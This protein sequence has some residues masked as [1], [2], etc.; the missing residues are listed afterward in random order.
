MRLEIRKFLHD[1][2]AELLGLELNKVVWAN[3]DGVKQKNPLVTLM[4][5]SYQGEAMEDK[6][7]TDVAGNMEIKTPTAFVLEIRYFG[8]KNSAPT[9]E[10]ERLVRQLERPTIVDKFFANGVA[11]LYAAPVQDIT[12]LLENSQQF[13]PRAA[14]DLHCR[15]T[16]QTIDD[17]GYI[18]E[19][20][21]VI[22]TID[23]ETGETVVD[24]T[25]KLIP[26]NLIR[27]EE[28]DLSRAI[29]VDFSVSVDK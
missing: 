9:D 29:N 16:S 14:V 27:G 19:V 26:G 3:Q 28:P 23:P 2:I 8:K 21:A 4:I 15:Y 20:D 5:Y 6:V 22:E 1:T 18:D 7:K 17:P 10:L 11:F 12:G 24:V 13:E 25:G